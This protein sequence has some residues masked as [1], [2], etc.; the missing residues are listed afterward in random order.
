LPGIP[1]YKPNGIHVGTDHYRML[2]GG[3]ELQR[4][5]R[6]ND[7]YGTQLPRILRSIAYFHTF[8][9]REQFGGIYFPY[10]YIVSQEGRIVT[11]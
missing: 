8:L 3:Q 4:G 5:G 2:G 6:C 1:S 9:S 10:I 7:N 11:V